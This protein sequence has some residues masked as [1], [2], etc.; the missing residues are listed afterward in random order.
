MDKKVLIFAGNSCRS[1]IA[2]ALINALEEF[3]ADS[4]GVKSKWKS[5]IQMLKNYLLKRN[6]ERKVSSKLLIK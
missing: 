5:K 6:L 4:S 3:S 2:E 1:I